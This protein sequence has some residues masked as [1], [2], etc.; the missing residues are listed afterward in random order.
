ML[1]LNE[2]ILPKDNLTPL[3]R[4]LAKETRLIAPVT[5][6]YGDTLFTV[7]DDID[8]AAI[9]LE[10]QPQASLKPFLLPQQETLAAYRNDENGYTFS[11]AEDEPETIYFGVRSCDLT[12]VLYTD[13]VFSR[14]VKDSSYFKRRN[15]SLIITIGCNHHFKKDR[16][17]S[18]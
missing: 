3:L 2:M 14:P 12:A 11:E 13:L 17:N 7:I 8:R 6:S 10:N 4:K 16:A 18:R 1:D 9:D 5:N 15:K